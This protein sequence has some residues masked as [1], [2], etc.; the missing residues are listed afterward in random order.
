MSFEPQYSA[1]KTIQY[2]KKKKTHKVI[3]MDYFFLHT[4]TNLKSLREKKT[5]TYV[6]QIKTWI[7]NL[8]HMTH[9]W[10]NL[11]QVRSDRNI[12]K[13]NNLKFWEQ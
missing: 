7:S 9:F 12:G 10:N 5:I 13:Q 8:V 11:H 3:I 4:I 1:L 2:L 6:I